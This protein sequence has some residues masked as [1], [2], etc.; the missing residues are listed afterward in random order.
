M[1]QEQAS[2]TAL[3]AARL[4]AA[5]Q[6]LERGRIFSDPLAVRVLGS[7]AEPLDSVEENDPAR[8]RLR[9]FIAARTRFAED[10]LA[11]SISRGL[12]QVVILGAGL[13]TYAY[14]SP[15]VDRLRIFEVDHPATQAWK[16]RRLAEVAISV[17]DTLTFAPI[18]FE[19]ETLA[20]GLAAV[21]LRSNERT[22]FTWL[23]V[24]PYLTD[25]AITATVGFVAGLQGGAQIVFDYVT[26]ATD[27]AGREG[28]AAHEAL[29]ARVA[30]AGEPF[31][32]A[33][34]PARLR[35]QLRGVGFRSVE[36]V[37]GGDL[38]ARYLPGRTAAGRASTAH[39]VS[40]AAE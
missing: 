15:L 31:R 20:D 28:Q 9:L 12:R 38:V 4:R 6:T 29:S 2:L 1:L 21:G 30:S 23:G 19:H 3:G 18:D 11:A 33:L 24:V 35:T 16:R 17:P 13:D 14:R 40:A 36:D 32:S 7:E 34:D 26:A 39:V 5:H 37:A 27:G 25:E 8:R 10:A 22:F